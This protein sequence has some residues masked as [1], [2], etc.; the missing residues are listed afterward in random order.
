MRPIKLKTL[1]K[2]IIR[3]AIWNAK[4]KAVS[5]TLTPR[6]RKDGLP[7]F[8]RFTPAEIKR[9]LLQ[10]KSNIQELMPYFIDLDNIGNYMNEYGGLVDL[11]VYRAL[12]K[13][14]IEPTYAMNLV[15]D[16]IW[17]TRM[18]ANGLVPIYDPIRLKLAEL[19]T[20]GP[21]AF[22]ERRL[23]DGLKFPYSEPGYKAELY[24]DKD[25][26]CMDFYSCA[27]H[28]FYKQFGEEEMKLFRRSWCTFDYSVAE[29]LVE[30]GKYQREHTLSDGDEV[31]D[32]RWFIDK[33]PPV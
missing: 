7:E 20:K 27:V 17:Q 23:R 30:G 5:Q 25:V 31:C 28:D 22:L 9:I 3:R 15:G 24:K 12:V 18:N 21:V 2:P 16:M 19:R 4:K 32:M 10:A 14:R 1:V 11:A 6:C 26:Y 33:Q 8:G 13:E 29:I